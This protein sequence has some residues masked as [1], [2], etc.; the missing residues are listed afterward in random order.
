MNFKKEIRFFSDLCSYIDKLQ[1]P[2]GSPQDTDS[3]VLHGEAVLVISH[4]DFQK[5]D[6]TDLEHSLTQGGVSPAVLAQVLLR[7]SVP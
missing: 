6:Y 3:A 7:T 1:D 5:T 2:Q 4:N